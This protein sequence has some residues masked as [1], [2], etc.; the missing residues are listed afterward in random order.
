MTTR[1][2]NNMIVK[3]FGLYPYMSNHLDKSRVAQRLDGIGRL[4]G[5]LRSPCSM[6]S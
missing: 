5:S 4:A 2:V 3:C 6:Q 1:T